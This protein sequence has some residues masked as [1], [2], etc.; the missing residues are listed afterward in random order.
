M[1]AQRPPPKTAARKTVAKKAADPN[2]PVKPRAPPKPN[3]TVVE[4]VLRSLRA[5]ETS[6]EAFAAA[7]AVLREN[8]KARLVELV[9]VVRGYS[10]DMSS[11]A[12]RPAAIG[13]IEQT[14]D[15]RWKSQ[16]RA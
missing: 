3:P 16:R 14:F 15:Q 7:V 5:A 13:V 12:K 1:E 11:I 2:A 8:K 10:G 6:P 9:E 4:D